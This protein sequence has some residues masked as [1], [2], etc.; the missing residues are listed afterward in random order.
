MITACFSLGKN[1]RNN[2][3]FDILNSDREGRSE[4]K[5]EEKFERREMKTDLNDEEES[6]RPSQKKYPAMSKYSAPRR[7]ELESSEEDYSDD[8]NT[9]YYLNIQEKVKRYFTLNI[10]KQVNFLLEFRLRNRGESEE[11]RP[12]KLYKKGHVIKYQS[13][14]QQ[15][16]QQM[17]Q[18]Y[19]N[20]RK[21][22]YGLWTKIGK[23][24]NFQ[25]AF[26]KLHTFHFIENEVTIKY[27]S[28]N[29]G[30]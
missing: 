29:I 7:R 3:L 4:Y 30:S 22:N 24:K 12:R 23:I 11:S 8:N 14:L 9:T 16:E 1:L 21:I 15:Y 28:N 26:W 13:K 18:Y 10:V 2:D 20:N 17:E 6:K 27:V 25:S 5:E 19:R